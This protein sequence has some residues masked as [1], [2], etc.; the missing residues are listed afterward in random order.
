[1]AFYRNKFTIKELKTKCNFSY[2]CDEKG[3][4]VDIIYY[5]NDYTRQK[6]ITKDV[7]N[8]LSPFLFTKDYF[9]EE[10]TYKIEACTKE[11]LEKIYDRI[12]Q[13]IKSFKED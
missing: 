1:M 3:K 4:I 9:L 6:V 12:I 8:L 5:Y 2:G 7:L 10:Y 11:E 13:Q